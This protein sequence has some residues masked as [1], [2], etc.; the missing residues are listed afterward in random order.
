[1]AHCIRLLSSKDR[2]RSSL[3]SAAVEL[4]S[5]A[6]ELNGTVNETCI[7]PRPSAALLVLRLR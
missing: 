4:G 6:V 7:N 1:M 5:A 2:R 3:S